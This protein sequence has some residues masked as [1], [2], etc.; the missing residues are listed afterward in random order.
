MIIHAWQRLMSKIY[1]GYEGGIW[2][3]E[4]GMK[5]AWG[6]GAGA[7]G[8]GWIPGG[9]DPVGGGSPG[10]GVG[11][12]RRTGAVV[13]PGTAARQGGTREAKTAGARGAVQHRGEERPQPRRRLRPPRPQK[14]VC[15]NAGRL[16]GGGRHSA[17]DPVF[18]PTLRK[19]CNSFLPAGEK[20]VGG[21][22]CRQGHRCT[23]GPCLG[24]QG[25]P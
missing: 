2:G 22:V 23:P 17:A 19:N 13:Y 7:R 3:Y 4:G 20:A 16:P 6:R 12:A 25:S 21:L 1:W 5:G 14:V 9:S 10:P 18:A 11:L 24:P 15:Q 8:P